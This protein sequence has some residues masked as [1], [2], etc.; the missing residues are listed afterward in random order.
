MRTIA[1]LV[2]QDAVR[3]GA[4][5]RGE[6]WRFYDLGHGLCTYDFFDQCPHR[7][8][9]AKCSFYLPKDSAKAQALEAGANLT[10][11][12]QEIPLQD[13]ERAAVEDGIE[14]ME[15]LVD[16]L[17]H[18]ITPDGRTPNAIKKTQRP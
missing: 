4:A 10:R 1:V 6:P 7:M 13:T 14:A 15:K 11:M 16:S 17:S 18:T 12:L 8:A 9:C 5:A 2:D 3:S